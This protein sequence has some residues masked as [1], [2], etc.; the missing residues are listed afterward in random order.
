M[1]FR[2][3]RKRHEQGS[4]GRL[5]PP[6]IPQRRPRSVRFGSFGPW[7]YGLAVLLS[8]LALLLT[9]LLWPLMENSIFFLFV[10][11]VAISAVYGGLGAG[12]VATLL[13]AL[14]SAFFLPLEYSLLVSLEGGLLLSVFMLVGLMVSWLTERRKQVQQGRLE[15]E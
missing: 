2:L 8:A 12:L 14:A 5:M 10:S 15:H 9:L 1:P 11:A 3:G 4:P 6:S 13:S 7:R